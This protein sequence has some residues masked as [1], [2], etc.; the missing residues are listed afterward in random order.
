MRIVLVLDSFD[1]SRGGLESYA[2]AW[3]SWLSR[4][5]HE[6]HVVAADG[7]DRAD[8]IRLHRVE[9]SAGDA[10]GRAR[11]LAA[12]AEALR[13]ALIHDFGAGLGGDVFHPA[14]G[15]RRA[16]RQGM[17]RALSGRKRWRLLL[18]RAWRRRQAALE[19][20]ERR[21][22][23]SAARIVAVSART[24]AELEGKAGADPGRISIIYNGVDCRHFVPASAVERRSVRARLGWPADLSVFLQVAHNFRLKGVAS[25]LHALASLRRQGLPAYLAIAGRGPDLEPYRLLVARLGIADRTTFLGAVADPRPLYAAADALVHPTFYDTCS[26]SSIEAFAAGLPV[27]LSVEDGA[28]ALMTDGVQGWLIRDPDDAAEVAFQMKRLMEPGLRQAMGAQARVLAE[29]H[30]MEA[31]FT[32][33]EALFLGLARERS[34]T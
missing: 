10:L 29:H 23:A 1:P 4:R 26:L 32:Q 18:S 13:P 17:L 21:Q 7:S 11:A 9:A 6:V 19:T 12:A 33:L 15:A 20:L 8:A 31:A 30:D 24:A 22:V 14:Y 27:A 2:A 34:P 16:S 28:A 5:G 25:S 3:A